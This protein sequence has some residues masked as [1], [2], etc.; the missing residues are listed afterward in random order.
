MP[1]LGPDPRFTECLV[2]TVAAVLVGHGYPAVSN[3]WDWS[4]L[5][6]ALAA[7]LYESK[8]K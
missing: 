4:E 8:E 2:N 3:V 5:E 6:M 1:H 7:F